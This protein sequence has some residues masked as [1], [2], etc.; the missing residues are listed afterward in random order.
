MDAGQLVEQLGLEHL[1]R[2]A[3]YLT[4]AHAG[5]LFWMDRHDGKDNAVLRNQRS[6]AAP[7]GG[8][9]RSGLVRGARSYSAGAA[10]TMC[11]SATAT[12]GRFLYRPACVENLDRGVRERNEVLLPGVEEVGQ[13]TA[14][15]SAGSFSTPVTR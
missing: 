10:S 1:R 5:E 13:A 3:Q 8:A 6:G 12:N 9:R 14:V 4:A 15:A 11:R 7:S 2:G